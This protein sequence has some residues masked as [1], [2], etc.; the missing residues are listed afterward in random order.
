[1]ELFRLAN[2]N[3]YEMTSNDILFLYENSLSALK[4]QMATAGNSGFYVLSNPSPAQPVNNW[5]IT[6]GKGILDYNVLINKPSIDGIPLSG[7]MTSYDLG[8]ATLSALSSDYVPYDFPIK[9]VNLRDKTLFLDLLVSQNDLS[10]SINLK[11]QTIYDNSSAISFEWTSRLFKDSLETNS[12]DYQNRNLIGDWNINGASL[13]GDVDTLLNHISALSSEI[14]NVSSDL[15]A[16]NTDGTAHLDIRGN[17]TSLSSE[18]LSTLELTSTNLTQSINNLSGSLSAYALETFVT[19][20]LTSHNE[21]PSAH[22]DIRDDITNI[23]N[24]LSAYELTANK[25]QHGGY[26]P[27]DG[28]GKVPLQHLPSTVLQYIGVWDASTNSPTLSSPDITKISNVYNVSVSGTQFGIAFSNGDW[29]IYNSL[30]VIEKSDNS[31]DVKSVNGQMGI[32]VLDTDDILDTA[33]R[34]YTN[35]TAIS[36]LANTSGTNTGDQDL[37]P[38]VLTTTLTSDYVPYSGANQSINL[39]SNSLST[40]GS[41]YA[42]NIEYILNKTTDLSSNLSDVYYP[43]TSAVKTYVTNSITDHNSSETSHQDIRNSAVTTFSDV[44]YLRYNAV[45]GTQPGESGTSFVAPSTWYVTQTNSLYYL[46]TRDSSNVSQS[47]MVVIPDASASN[48]NKTITFRKSDLTG[49]LS[50]ITLSS[51]GGQNIGP[52]TTLIFNH[53]SDFIQLVANEWEFSGGGGYKWRQSYDERQPSNTV[54]VAKRGECGYSSIQTAINAIK[55]ANSYSNPYLIAVQP[56]VYNE[57]ITLKDG[58][59][60]KGLGAS[61]WE[62]RIQP[63]SGTVLTWADNSTYSHVDNVILVGPQTVNTGDNVIKIP[64]G[65]HFMSNVVLEWITSGPFN[66]TEMVMV[67]AAGNSD[68]RIDAS[69]IFYIQSGLTQP[70]NNRQRLFKSIGQARLGMVGSKCTALV[71]DSSDSIYFLKDESTNT[72]GKFWK[73][74]SISISV[75][76]E[77]FSGNVKLIEATGGTDSIHFQSNN[78]LLSAFPAPSGGNY[79]TMYASYGGN[80]DTI[81]SLGNEIEI[82]GFGANY[83]AILDS[84]ATLGSHFDDTTTSSD[85]SGTGTFKYVYS[86]IDGN[87]SVSNDLTVENNVIIPALSGDNTIVISDTNGVLTDTTMSIS[88][89]AAG[90]SL[91]NVIEFT[92]D[93]LI[94]EKIEGDL[95]VTDNPATSGKVLKY[96][97][98]TYTYSVEMSRE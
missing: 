32:V 79:A 87:L 19:S 1:M 40:T 82:Q 14:D 47:L 72:E 45:S 2:L 60:L 17:I 33:T 18:L 30:G 53:P 94:N 37:G 52:T 64:N 97:D 98:G 83:I 68:T 62:V 69:Q 57:N 61:P 84:T 71:N 90:G 85:L 15:T 13:S 31:D 59:N 51:V 39:A 35:D 88:Q 80:G 43:T 34:R 66:A 54:V 42:D 22:L 7:D 67:S 16:H 93:P 6:M 23:S 4:T 21:N 38:Y 81:H 26:T 95:W 9:D 86:P 48:L 89:G 75:T 92:T 91:L 46:D 63:A 12:L 36:R 55:D 77:D 24:G 73:D 58:V 74:N 41:I 49:D 78:M 28:G 8:L 29:A 3:N 10:S 50:T 76:N 44:V 11:N 70:G 20:S 65:T 27:L 56:G 5:V 25:G 96:Y